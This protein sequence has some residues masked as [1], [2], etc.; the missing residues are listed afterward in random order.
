[1]ERKEW[2]LWLSITNKILSLKPKSG[3]DVMQVKTKEEYW[4][5]VHTLLE[6]GYRVQ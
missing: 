1:M 3:F 5:K 6:T 2:R 4:K